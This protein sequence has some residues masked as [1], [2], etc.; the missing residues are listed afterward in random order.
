MEGWSVE[1][2]ACSQVGGRE[3]PFTSQCGLLIEVPEAGNTPH[4]TPSVV[5]L[6]VS[7]WEAGVPN[8]Q[9]LT[10]GSFSP[11]NRACRCST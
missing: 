6:L 11:R 2:A 3:T 7:E 5:T 4:L 8:S 10:R 1:K 9:G